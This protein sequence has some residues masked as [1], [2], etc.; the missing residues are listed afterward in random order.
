[1]SEDQQPRKDMMHASESE[2][3]RERESEGERERERDREREREN[4]VKI[5]EII[6]CCFVHV[7]EGGY[8]DINHHNAHLSS[9]SM[10]C[11]CRW[12]VTHTV[13]VTCHTI[14][15]PAH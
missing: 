7:Y 15:F 1:M 3:E 12:H 8:L 14:L 10:L 11:K 6:F 2:I 5:V 9:P 4:N 13:N